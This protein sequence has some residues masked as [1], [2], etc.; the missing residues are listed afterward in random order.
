MTE[1]RPN[2][3]V[4]PGEGTDPAPETPPVAEATDTQPQESA[5]EAKSDGQPDAPADVPPSQEA[6]PQTSSPV[7]KKSLAQSFPPD[8]KPVRAFVVVVFENGSVAAIPDIDIGVEPK[9]PQASLADIRHACSDL[10]LDLQGVH[11]ASVVG[12]E[13]MPRLVKVINAAEEAKMRQKLM[14]GGSVMPPVDPRGFRK[15]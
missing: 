3:S 2:L 14:Q 7:E 8:Q 4:V 1:D 12:G 10:M 9:L 6:A 13:L 11:V 15:R 5:A